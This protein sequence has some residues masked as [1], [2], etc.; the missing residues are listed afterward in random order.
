MDDEITDRSYWAMQYML[1]SRRWERIGL[2]ISAEDEEICDDSIQ[3]SRVPGQG[4]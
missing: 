4:S 2:K 1:H 3:V